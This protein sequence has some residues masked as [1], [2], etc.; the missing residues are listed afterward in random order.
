[1]EVSNL[2]SCIVQGLTIIVSSQKQ[3]REGT[4]FATIHYHCAQLNGDQTKPHLHPELSKRRARTRMRRY[5]CEG[6]LSITIADNEY[7]RAR[8]RMQHSEAHPHYTDI[9]LPEKIQALI[10]EMKNSSASKVSQYL[11]LVSYQC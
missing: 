8:V 11:N 1:M 5:S 7:S 10:M 6:R 2:L 3:K 9:S 4:G